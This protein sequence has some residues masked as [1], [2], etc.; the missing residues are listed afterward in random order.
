MLWPLSLL[1]SVLV[2]CRVL[3]YRWGWLRTTRLPVPVVIIGNVVVGGA[4]KTPTVV[5]VVQ[6]LQ[7]QGHRPGVVSRGHGRRAAGA[8]QQAPAVMEVH[9]DTPAHASGDE[10]ALIKRA[11]GV[12]VFVGRDRVAA[13]KALLA[14]HPGITVV[15]CDDGLQHLALHADVAVAVFDERGLGNGWLLPA[16]LLREPWPKRAGRPVD[17]VLHTVAEHSAPAYPIPT[18]AGLP[19]FRALKCL[20]DQATH[21]GGAAV[22]LKHLGALRPTALAGIAKPQ[23]FFDMLAHAGVSTSQ[24]WPLA[25]HQHFDALVQHEKLRAAL[26]TGLLC[27][28]KDAVKLFPLLRTTFGAQSPLNAWSVG[29][30]FTPEPGFF[31]ALDQRLSSLHGPKTA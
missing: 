12:P 30:V 15:V 14:Q 18:P 27:T 22:P 8:N 9:A 31:N 16:G 21:V 1:Y 10:P 3:A 28:E 2:R 29:L 17:I 25:D 24:T 4:G 13:G 6:H 26:Q 20:S 11:T 7:R 23:A 19:Q 5:A